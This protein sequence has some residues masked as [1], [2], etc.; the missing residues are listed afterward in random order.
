MQVAKRRDMFSS[1]FVRLFTS[2]FV[3]ITTT[4][5]LGS[6]VMAQDAEAPAAPAP[7][8]PLVRNIVG[9]LGAGFVSMRGS[10]VNALL[11]LD[12]TLV[13]RMGPFQIGGGAE[14]GSGFLHNGRLGGAALV[15]LGAHEWMPFGVDLIGEVGLRHYIAV[16][17]GFFSGPGASATVPYVGLRLGIDVPVGALRRG[18]ARPVFGF[19]AY[20]RYEPIQVKRSYSYTDSDWF[21]D[22][23]TTRDESVKIGGATEFGL[24]LRVGFDLS[25]M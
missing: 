1:C 22:R 12:T 6:P 8:P 15:G 9:D 13:A 10:D 14:C 4:V 19:G 16:S 18:A 23:M 5:A 7:A 20:A 25:R 3:A 21:S 2:V 17:P 24:A 11:T